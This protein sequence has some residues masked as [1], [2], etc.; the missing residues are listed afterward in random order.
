MF[1]HTSLWNTFFTRIL[2]I[3]CEPFFH[4]HLPS[5]NWMAT[6]LAV[7]GRGNISI[8]DEESPEKICWA[9][10]LCLAS[11]H[12]RFTRAHSGESVEK[13]AVHS[14][15]PRVFQLGHVAGLCMGREGAVCQACI[16]VVSWSVFRVSFTGSY[17][18]WSRVGKHRLHLWSKMSV[19]SWR[20]QGRED[21]VETSSVH[22]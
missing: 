21:Q 15:K 7:C 3:L 1:P 19:F 16:Q 20:Q 11:S 4:C 18:P 17:L 14:G 12:L 5:A 6:N 10:Y 22:G 8:V 9:E 13:D 2:V